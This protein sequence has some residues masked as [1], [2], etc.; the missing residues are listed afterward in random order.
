M[1]GSTGPTSGEAAFSFV[2]GSPKDAAPAVPVSTTIVMTFNSPIDPASVTASTVSLEPGAS[3]D[4][5]V[6]GTTLRFDPW[7]DLAPSK[8]YVVHI[9]PE[10]RGTNGAT[11]GVMADPYGF[12]TGTSPDTLPTQGPRPR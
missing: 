3:G 8:H 6:Q 1:G 4:L 10:L 2:S 7:S 12:K 5:T 9:S 11:L